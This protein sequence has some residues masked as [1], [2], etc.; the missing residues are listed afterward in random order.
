MKMEKELFEDYGFQEGYELAKYLEDYPCNNQECEGKKNCSGCIN[1]ALVIVQYKI[2]DKRRA[3]IARSKQAVFVFIL[4]CCSVCAAVAQ[5]D[6]SKAVPHPQTGQTMIIESD[7]DLFMLNA[8]ETGEYR[9]AIYFEKNGILYKVMSSVQKCANKGVFLEWTSAER[10]RMSMTWP[11][12]SNGHWYAV[13]E[14][15]C[16]IVFEYWVTD[17]SVSRKQYDFECK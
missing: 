9:F 16:G 13:L 10:E 8:C 2:E 7:K 5:P 15:Q 3:L 14:Y 11:A 12:M 6:F 4:A 1:Y 17:D